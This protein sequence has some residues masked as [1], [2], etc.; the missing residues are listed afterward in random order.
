MA[1]FLTDGRTA[2]IDALQ[3]DATIA[4]LVKTWRDWAPGLR[5]RFLLEPAYCPLVAIY[6]SSASLD[7]RYDIGKDLPQDIIV[8]I[9]VSEHP[10]EAEDIIVPMIRRVEL[11]TTNNLGLATSGLANISIASWRWAAYRNEKAALV[12]WD[13][14]MI[15]RLLWIRRRNT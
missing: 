1:N 15:V 13:V 5:V 3:G 12:Q 8:R 11:T 4:G 2:L 10:A 9:V 14:A 6:P 7:Y